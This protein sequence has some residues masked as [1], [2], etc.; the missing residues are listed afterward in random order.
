[1]Q[2]E[3]AEGQEEFPPGCILEMKT[4]VLGRMPRVVPSGVHFIPEIE[5]GP[6]VAVRIFFAVVPEMIMRSNESD[7]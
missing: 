7:T 3:S 1:M 2:K 5:D 4:E 6:E